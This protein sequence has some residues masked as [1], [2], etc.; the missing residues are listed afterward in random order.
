MILVGG[1]NRVLELREEESR[2]RQK[3]MI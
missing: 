2:A 1:A 3:V